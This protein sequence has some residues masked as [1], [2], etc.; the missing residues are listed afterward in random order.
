MRILLFLLF[1]INFVPVSSQN[2]HMQNSTVVN[3]PQEGKQTTIKYSC[4]VFSSINRTWCYDI[5]KNDKVFIHQ[6]SIPAAS[7]NQG[8]KTKA[9]AKKVARLVIEKLEKGEMP[10]SVTIDEMKNLKVL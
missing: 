5:Y 8:F 1:I 3:N 4:K 9:D 7:G 6:T 10:P 2:T